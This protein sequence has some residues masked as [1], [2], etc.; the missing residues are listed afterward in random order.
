MGDGSVRLLA[1]VIDGETLA[2]LANRR[3]GKAVSAPE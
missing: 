1:T 3:D 2:R